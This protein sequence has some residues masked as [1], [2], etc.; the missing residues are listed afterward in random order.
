MSKFDFCPLASGSKGNTLYVETPG[1]KFL[2]DVGIGIRNLESRLKE[3]GVSLAEIDAILITHEHGDHIHGL[4][5]IYNKWGIPV[6]ANSETAKGIVS[7]L[8]VIP[9]FKIFTTGEPFSL[10]DCEITPFTIQHD[11]V[12]PVAFTIQREGIKLGVA[13]DLGF[14]TTLVKKHLRDCD[15]LYVEANHE[16]SWVQA[17]SRPRVYKERVLSRT[18]H[19]SNQSCGE[20]LLDVAHE[21]LQ[22][23]YLAHLSSEC[24]SPEKALEVINGM[25]EKQNLALNITIA[26]QDKISFRSRIEAHVIA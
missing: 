24:N 21:K 25:L 7:A 10:G 5:A 6:Y 16:P 22:Q 9:N 15:I 12:D 3:I 26:Y 4:G 20:I 11:T 23:V 17:C 18:G 8:G 14:A 13:A 19:L 2:I 1:V